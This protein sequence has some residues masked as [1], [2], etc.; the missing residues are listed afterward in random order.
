MAIKIR[1][2]RMGTIGKPFYRVVAADSRF[3]T[4]GRFLEILGW[5]DPKQKGDNFSLNLER[6]NYWIGTG[7]QL[8]GTA[9]SLIKKAEAGQGVPVG[10]ALGEKASA[11]A[12][13]AAEASELQEA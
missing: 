6:V 2:R 5:Y 3:A 7:A 8:S 10:A 4:T 1:L 9:A 12:V 13:P 11:E